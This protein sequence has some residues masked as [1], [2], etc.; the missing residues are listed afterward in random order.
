MEV[1]QLF[2]AAE[3]GDLEEVRRLLQEDPE[4]AAARNE[5]GVSLVLFTR[6]HGHREILDML[7]ETRPHVDVFEAAAT[8]RGDRLGALLDADPGLCHA[9]SADGWSPLHLAS[10]FGYL[11]LVAL[12]LARGAD[13]MIRSTNPLNNTPLHAAMAGHHAEVALLLLEHGSDPNGRQASGWAPLHEAARHGDLNLVGMLLDHGADPGVA[14]D[15]GTTP[16][17][18]ARAA[19]HTALAS[20]LERHTHS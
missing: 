12:L 17:S 18:L 15:D 9:T 16:S 8:G 1:Q 14:S 20:V 11:D 19:G 4:G 2:Q 6:Y 10:F 3:S 7:L 13:P 5:D